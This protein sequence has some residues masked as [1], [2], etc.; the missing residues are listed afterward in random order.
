M[1]R[2]SVRK[3]GLTGFLCALLAVCPIVGHA[4]QP[5]PE[6]AA[7]ATSVLSLAELPRQARETYALIQEGGP[8][9]HDKDG[10]VFANRE[11]LLPIYPRGYYREY[12]VRTPGVRSRGARRIVCGG[13]PRTPDACYYTSDHYASYRKIAP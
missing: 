9:P 3:L 2:A 1:L 5:L 7:A 6:P 10:S 11:R 4:K 8:F 12:T 13:R